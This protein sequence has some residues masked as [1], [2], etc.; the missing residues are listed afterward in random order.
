[1]VVIVRSNFLEFPFEEI[2]LRYLHALK[3]AGTTKK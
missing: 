1:V 2:R 3:Q